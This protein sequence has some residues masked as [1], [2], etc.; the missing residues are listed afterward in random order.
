[1]TKNGENGKLRKYYMFFCNT[2][3]LR[4]GSFL[5]A[6]ADGYIEIAK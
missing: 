2:L 6:N 4:I 3:C 1:L 5:F